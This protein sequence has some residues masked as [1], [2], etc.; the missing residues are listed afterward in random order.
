LARLDEDLVWRKKELTEIKFLIYGAPYGNFQ[1]NLRMGIVM[2]YAHWEGYIKSAGNYYI[3]YLTQQNL[4]YGDITDNFIALALK[5][6]IR[7]CGTTD[8]TSVHCKIVNILIN[9]LNSQAH[10]PHSYD[11]KE[12][13]ML[14]Y[15][16]FS[17]LLLTL[18]IDPSIF[19]LKQTLIDFVLIDKRN[20]IAHG[21][22]YPVDEKDFDTLYTEIIP[23]LE[24]VKSLIFNAAEKGLY[25]RPN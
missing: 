8:K 2:I 9:G 6:Q 5:A 20:K 25:K 21:K 7:E 16:L 3:N 10:F 22:R 4:N 17:E 12:K 1:I 11:V 15:E 13:A 14:S 24:Q 23:I 19:E 18:G